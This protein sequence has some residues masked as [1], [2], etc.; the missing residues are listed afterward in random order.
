[1]VDM[2]IVDIDDCA[3]ITCSGHGQC[4]DGIAGYTCNCDVGYTGNN[5]QTGHF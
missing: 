4:V 2:V 5:C 1:M 3:G